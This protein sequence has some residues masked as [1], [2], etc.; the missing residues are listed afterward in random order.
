LSKTKGGGD[1][2]VVKLNPTGSAL[3]YSAFLGGSSADAG[4]GI[5]VDAQG[6]AH[7]T[8][9]TTSKDFPVF[10]GFQS[11]PGIAGGDPAGDTSWQS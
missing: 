9:K 6:Q 5:A 8:G 1:I 4:L 11:T 10:G 7:V 2:L 3:V